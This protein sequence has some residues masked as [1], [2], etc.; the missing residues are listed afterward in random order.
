[1]GGYLVSYNSA[2]EQRLVETAFAPANNYYLGIEA[3][4]NTT[5]AGGTFVMLDGTFLGNTTPSSSN[6]YRHWWV[7]RL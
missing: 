5:I 2:D 4:G 7:V 1:M 6:P 3:L